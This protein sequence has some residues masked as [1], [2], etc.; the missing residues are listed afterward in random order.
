MRTADGAE[1]QRRAAQRAGGDDEPAWDGVR[2]AGTACRARLR[3]AVGPRRP[4]ERH[5][6]LGAAHARLTIRVP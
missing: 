2:D 6:A 4:A 1:R 5:E 3:A